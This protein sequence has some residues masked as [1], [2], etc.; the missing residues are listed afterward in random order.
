MQYY[1]YTEKYTNSV[2]NTLDV[3]S[4]TNYVDKYLYKT[5]TTTGINTYIVSV[6]LEN[7]DLAAFIK[8]QKVDLEPLTKEEWTL[9]SNESE[10]YQTLKTMKRQNRS[11]LVSVATISYK[12]FTFDADES[13]MGRMANVVAVY[14]FKFNR[15]IA[16]GTIASKAFEV[17]KDVIPWRDAWNED[18]AMTVEELGYLL[19]LAM[20]RFSAI[21][22]N[23]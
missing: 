20:L 16:N 5:D 15:L 21:W 7:E 12:G 17:Y 18:R 4:Y 8:L 9:M 1:K 13:A 3:G 19:Q 6:N 10:E 22:L 14:N 11:N 2:R 23:N